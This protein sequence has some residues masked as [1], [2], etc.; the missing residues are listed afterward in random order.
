MK[1]KITILLLA[2]SLTGFAQSPA[3]SPTAV[4]NINSTIPFQG[5]D[6]TEAF[7]GQGEYEIFYD[8]I[9]GTL[10]KPIILVDGFDPT[11]TRTIPMIYDM[12]NY[13]TDQNLATD[14]RNQ[15]F[16]VVI[17]NFP[18]YTRP[19][20]TTQ[21]LGGSDYIQ[22]NAMILVELINTINALKTGEEQ[23]VVI[24][25]S[26]GGL[27]ARYGLRYMEMNSMD[28]ETRLFLSFDAPHRGA[29][30]PIGFQH[31]F[32]Y[33]AY[34]PLG[35][36]TL[37]VVVDAML[38]S[39]A[40][41]QMLID[42]FEGHLDGGSNFEFD[43]DI[44]LPTGKPNYRNA[45]QAELDAMGFPQNT[46]NIAIANG[47]TTGSTNGTPGMEVMDHV[48][49]VT[50][51]QRAV[52]NLHFTP[53]AGTMTEVSHF[54]G[55]VK[56]FGVWITVYESEAMSEAPIDSDGLDSSPGGKFDVT[57]LSDLAGSN[58]MLTEFFQNLNINYFSFI[59]TRS[60]LAMEDS[61]DW[62]APAT[63]AT[64]FAAISTP[65]GNENHVTLTTANLAFALNEI[66]NPLSVPNQ[67]LAGIDVKNPISNEIVIKSSTELTNAQISVFDLSGKVIYDSAHNIIGQLSI[68]LDI[69]DGIYLMRISHQ[70]G[71]VVKKVVKQ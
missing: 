70:N 23:N 21:I 67:P 36:A 10:D 45:F 14:L 64:P 32:N 42:Q 12:L 66:L 24:G 16:D 69:E 57:S 20:T 9:D 38:R 19:S 27:I 25:P 49:D 55:Q 7:V 35:D 71:S 52:I 43:Q 4:I 50:D 44:T 53:E 59:P 37:Q 17:L 33:M 65:T 46:R 68:P 47:S 8:N 60:A 54:Q 26:M 61:A 6:E 11:N 63:G 29:N 62:Y 22:R 56:V 41:R 40:S 18:N 15:G 13:G 1:S 31:L 34:G 30:I 2:I 51:S 58:A 39:P 28:H 48:F 3:Q 5:Y